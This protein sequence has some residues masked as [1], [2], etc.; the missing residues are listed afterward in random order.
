MLLDTNAFYWAVTDSPRL[1][2]PARAFLAAGA[3]R[4]LVSPLLVYELSQKNTKGK[5]IL[6]YPASEFV[7]LG[8]DQ[9]RAEELPLFQR[10]TDL[11]DSIG[12]HHRDPFDRLLA[13]QAIG[14]RIAI[15]SSD[16]IFESYGIRRIW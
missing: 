3:E 11:S 7:R 10:H 12:W 6:D 14:E 9:L 15:V 5:L 16:A 4:L 13:L 8:V 2:P 1:S